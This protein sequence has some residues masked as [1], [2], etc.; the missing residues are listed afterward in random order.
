MRRTYSA[1]FLTCSL[2]LMPSV[3]LADGHDA[4]GDFG[5]GNDRADEDIV[6]GGGS[7]GAAVHSQVVFTNS[8]GSDEAPRTA[9]PVSGWEPPAC[10]Y[11]PRTATETRGYVHDALENYAASP[12][13][14]ILPSRERL[15]NHYQGGQPYQ[16]YNLDIE[17]DGFFWFGVTNP[18]R[19]DDPLAT[20][21]QGYARWV[22]RGE[23]P[24]GEPNM[25]TPETLAQ[26]AYDW[27][28]LP[29]TEI[30]LSPDVSQAQTV[31]LPTWIWHDG[32]RVEEVSATA[33]LERL[34]L[35]ATTT[36]VPSA[37][38]LDAGTDD[39]ESHPEGGQCQ[40]AAN[41]TIG[42]PYQ[43]GRAGDTPPCGI[44]YLRATN[45]G[46]YPLTATITWSISWTGTG[47]S[48]PQ[49]LPSA[50]LETSHDLTVQEIQT[51]VR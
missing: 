8:A 4:G 34:G 46:T 15:L 49:T 11:E 37:L 10:W 19:S 14:D 17:D 1:I 35:E 44:T 24:D 43:A 36:A 13:E 26:A 47:T 38:T 33:A 41:G 45:G 40:L 23:I 12:E 50:V 29:D 32:E 22:T 21:C 48:T 51:I 28:P 18:G 30:S 6:V 27:L 5:G 31:N 39:A 2:V 16:D 20:T 3:S 25:V 9:M 7:D 42:E